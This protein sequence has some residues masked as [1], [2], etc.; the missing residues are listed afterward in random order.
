MP[1]KSRGSCLR[2]EIRAS[3]E[4][5]QG[6]Y[7]WPGYCRLVFA[8]RTKWLPSLPLAVQTQWPMM[9]SLHKVH[10]LTDFNDH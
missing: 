1:K 10:A 2:D 3:P 7:G 6:E 8:D 9:D 5:C 4:G